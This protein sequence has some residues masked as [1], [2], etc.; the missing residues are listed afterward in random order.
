MTAEF[1]YN[2]LNNNGFIFNLDRIP[3]TTFR[4]TACTLPGISVPAAPATFPGVNQFFPGG[5]TEF[6]PLVMTF[7]VDENLKNYEEIYHWITQQRYSI[8]KDYVPKSDKETKMVSDGT[9]VTMTNSSNPNRVFS[10][11]DLF[12]ISIG[13][14]QFDTSVTE[15][16]PVTCDVTF[17]YS[18]FSMKLIKEK[19]G[20]IIIN[21]PN[22]SGGTTP[23]IVPSAMQTLD[24]A[25]LLGLAA[26]DA[27]NKAATKQNT[28]ISNINIKT[29]NGNS[30]L[31]SGNLTLGGGVSF[32]L[33]QSISGHSVLTL[34]TFGNAILADS[35]DRLS[36]IIC[37]I[38]L[39]SANIGDLISV[40]KD[41]EIEHIGW[42][43]TAGNPIYLGSS[44]G[45]TQTLPVGS[46][47]SKVLGVALT[48]TKVLIEIQP[49][50]FIN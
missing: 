19:S 4:V 28:L 30:I 9:L 14:L 37:G 32:K 1:N 24:V 12:P 22:S 40:V 25:S 36:S 34:N 8:G 26:I 3:Q 39:N 31:G 50:I 38:C 46:L 2:N 20:N 33:D 5:N 49:A 13:N 6:E 44:G 35:S 43:F 18:Y 10:F 47:F 48:S 17:A 27:A 29:L 41:G 16:T 23:Y 7:I 21:L 11:K 45:I 15:T 42:T